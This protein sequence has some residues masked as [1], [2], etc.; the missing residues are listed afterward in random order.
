MRAFVGEFACVGTCVCA[1]LHVC[2]QCDALQ[3]G[4]GAAL[5]QE[6]RHLLYTGIELNARP[7]ARSSSAGLDPVPFDTFCAK[8]QMSTILKQ[9]ILLILFGLSVSR[10]SSLTLELDV[11]YTLNTMIHL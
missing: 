5:L 7:L 1:C 8:R 9:S 6:R 3:N 2:L 4:P 10:C 11:N